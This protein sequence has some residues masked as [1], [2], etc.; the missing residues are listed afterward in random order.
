MSWRTVVG[1]DGRIAANRPIAVATRR[2]GDAG[3]DA[4]PGWPAAGSI[5]RERVH[6]SPDGAKQSDVGTDRADDARKFSAIRAVHFT[7]V[8]RAH[9][10]AVRHRA[11]PARRHGRAASG[12]RHADSKMRSSVPLFRRGF[13]AAGKAGRARHHPELA[14][15]FLRLALGA[16]DGERFW[17]M[18]VRTHRQHGQQQ[19]YELHDQVALVI[20]DRIDRSVT[21]V[22]AGR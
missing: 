21:G 12:T 13:D 4:R 14:L 22:I 16:L 11:S 7:L 15:E 2:L 18:A 19:H 17:K 8:R 20:R 3:R 6:D 5:D 10:A 1:H 9:G